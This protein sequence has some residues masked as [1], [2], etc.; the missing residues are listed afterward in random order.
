MEATIIRIR[1]LQTH[2]PWRNGRRNPYQDQFIKLMYDKIRCW[3]CLESFLTNI[4]PRFRSST[5]NKPHFTD[6]T[7]QKNSQEKNFLV[8]KHKLR[9]KRANR[10]F[11]KFLFDCIRFQNCFYIAPGTKF[12]NFKI[13]N[14]SGF[15]FWAFLI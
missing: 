15:V 2:F 13:S 6:P 10:C 4:N 1:A 9:D 14:Q 3:T 8:K 7:G 5:P 11:W 12:Q